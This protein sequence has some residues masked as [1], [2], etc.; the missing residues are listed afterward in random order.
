MLRACRKVLRPLVGE[1]RQTVFP[2]PAHTFHRM[3]TSTPSTPASAKPP[4][5]RKA[6]FWLFLASGVL[7]VGLIA[8]ALLSKKGKEQPQLVSTEKAVVRTIT[9]IVTATGKAQPEKEVKI[10]PEVAGE[11]IALPFKEGAVVKKGQ[12]IVK[13]K[14]DYYQAQVEQT[15][16]SLASAQAS[17]VL[18][19]AKLNKAEQDFAQSQALF[20][21]KLI[22]DADFTA[23]K[24][25]LDVSRAE[26][27]ASLA[28]IRHTEGVLTQSRDYLAKTEIVAPMDG[29]ISSLSSE[30]GE[31][32]VGTGQFSGTEIM[33]VADLGTMEIRVKVNENDIVNVKVGDHALLSIDAFPGRRFNGEVMEISSSAM[34]QTGSTAQSATSEEVSNFLVKIRVLDHG[35]VLRP[36][37]SATADI[38]TQTVANVV[39]VPIQSVTVRAEGGK[40]TDELKQQQA[41]EAREKSGNELDLVSERELAR[42][43][44][45][46]LQNFVFLVQDGAVKMVPVE[47][48]IQDTTHIEI[49]SGI[50]AGDEVV[51]GSY[52]AIS[53]LLKDGSR[54]LVEKSTA[55]AS[56]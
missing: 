54:I 53:R 24:T 55:P 28:Q 23:A 16:A 11:L 14:P 4:R 49:K 2:K 51:S 22:S 26:Y 5:K 27:E 21:K 20:E 46:K 40:T 18:S 9:Q 30:V 45:E 39:A 41:K 44:R 19:K 3:T 36:G 50:K 29:T 32:L 35:G 34:G 13:I 43:N 42:R 48:G 10:S 37:M 38:E 17:S 12:L 52:A 15:E 25:L 47:I 7:V 31:R 6:R 8:G 1:L 56:K 33:R